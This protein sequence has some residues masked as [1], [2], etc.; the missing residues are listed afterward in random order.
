MEAVRHRAGRRVPRAEV[1]DARARGGEHGRRRQGREAPQPRE[2]EK[3]LLVPPLA[4][5][6]YFVQKYYRAS[7]RELQRCE[8]PV[9]RRRLGVFLAQRA[10]ALADQLARRGAQKAPA[11]T[12]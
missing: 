10:H 4:A 8:R 11:A 2:V 12:W 6:Y 9:Y 1:L 7:S 3:L 5:F